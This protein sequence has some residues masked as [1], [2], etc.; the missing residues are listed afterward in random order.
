MSDLSG[1]KVENYK[2]IESIGVG[3]MGEVYKAIHETLDRV[4]ALKVIHPEL[5]SNAEI[6]KR[7]YKE[8]KIQAQMTHPNIV[9]VFD[10]LALPV[11]L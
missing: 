6:I 1:Q 3:G 7:F 9:T 8:A 5:L 4:V 10:F 2:I 11:V